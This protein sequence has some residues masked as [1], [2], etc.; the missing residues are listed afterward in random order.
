MAE[1][2]SFKQTPLSRFLISGIPQGRN[3]SS[4]Q[5][6]EFSYKKPTP[7]I[8]S[9]AMKLT[10]ARFQKTEILNETN[11]FHNMRKYCDK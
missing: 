5:N 4:F 10:A 11:S 6:T 2:S 9:K 1:I 3:R 7:W 8:K